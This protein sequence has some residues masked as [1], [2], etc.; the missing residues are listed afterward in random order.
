MKKVLITFTGGTFSQGAFEFAKKLN[1][2]SPLLLT[3]F[4]LPEVETPLFELHPVGASPDEVVIENNIERFISLCEQNK[5]A[6]KVHTGSFA[7][8]MPQ[9][10][11]ETRFADLYIASSENFYHS[12]ETEDNSYYLRKA[13]HEA[14]CPLLIVPEHCEFPENVIFTYDGSGSSTFAIKQFSYLLP[15]LCRHEISVVFADENGH[16]ELPHHIKLEE[17]CNAHFPDTKY[18]KLGHTQRG[19]IFNWLERHEK[20][21]VVTG[22]GSRS[23]FA[24]VFKKSFGK[25]VIELHK[26]PVFIAHR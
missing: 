12:F 22:A 20:S 19:L 24:E 14:E 21:I 23:D 18:L 7:L 9:L 8:S 10:I 15:E 26:L 11:N 25:E 13:L 16:S 4:F 6:Y 2:L 5:I 1:Q 17:L 3:G